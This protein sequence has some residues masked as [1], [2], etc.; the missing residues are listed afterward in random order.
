IKTFKRTAMTITTYCKLDDIT[1]AILIRDKGSLNDHYTDNNMQVYIYQLYDFFVEVIMGNEKNHVMNI[2]PYKRGFAT[3][4]V[5]NSRQA[6][7]S[8][9]YAYRDQYNFSI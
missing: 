8:R 9:D 4:T 6:D 1:K 3:K 5:N 7:D 2:I